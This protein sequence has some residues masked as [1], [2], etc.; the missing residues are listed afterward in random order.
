M[1]TSNSLHALY[2]AYIFWGMCIK[3]PSYLNKAT[4][5]SQNFESVE[6]SLLLVLVQIYNL[7]VQ[8]SLVYSQ[9]SNHV[10][11]EK[12][13]W[14]GEYVDISIRG[15]LPWITYQQHIILIIFLSTAWVTVMSFFSLSVFWSWVCLN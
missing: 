2:L 10:T 4:Q 13:P 11:E 3:I 14:Y 15:L 12:S 6:T 8:S 9:Q 5:K 7:W 1:L